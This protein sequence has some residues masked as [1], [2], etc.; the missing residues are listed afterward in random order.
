MKPIVEELK[1]EYEGKVKVVE[2]NIDNAEEL[3]RSLGI[4]SIPYFIINKD[5]QQAWQKLG[6]MPKEELKT[7]IEE[8]LK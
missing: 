1:H 8:S 3:S 2:I 7:A 4:R 6:A 5:G